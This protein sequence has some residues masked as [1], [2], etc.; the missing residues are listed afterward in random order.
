MSADRASSPWRFREGFEYPFSSLDPMSAHVDPPAVAVYET[1]LVKRPDSGADPLLAQHFDVADD[2]VTW[3]MQLRPDLRFHSGA[4]CDAAAVVEALDVLRW[5]GGDDRQ[6]WY[7]DAVDTVRVTG[8]DTIEFT[9]V[10]PSA[11]FHSLLWGTHTAIHNEA[12]RR[13]TGDAFGT[14]VADGT[15]PYRLTSWSPERIEARRWDDYRRSGSTFLTPQR[16]QTPDVIEWVSVPDAAERLAM[17]EDGELDCIHLPPVSE[18][19]RLVEDPG[20]ASY[21]HPQASSMYLTLDWKQSG[22]D[23][24]RVRQAVSAAID[25]AELVTEVFA[26][27]A[28]AAAGPLPPGHR[29]CDPVNGVDYRHDPRRAAE[30]LDA[31]GWK[32]GPDGVRVRDGVPLAVRCVIQD[33][34]TFRHVARLVAGQLAEIGVRLDVDPRRGFAA[35]YEA[36]ADAPPAVISKWLWPD[37]VDALIGFTSTS[38]APF[39][40]WSNASSAGLDAAFRDWI[41]GESD[42]QLH[43]AAAAAQRAFGEDLPYVP[44]L[45]PDDVWVWRDHDIGFQPAA[46]TLYPSYHPLSRGPL[47]AE[48]RRP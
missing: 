42:E 35:F 46:A 34:P 9:L 24:L 40:N 31:A 39:P 28:T 41:R 27:H 23:D 33:D 8:A 2:G 3:R 17:F 45:T 32:M 14:E 11:R 15:G 30:L 18:M 16:S 13:S 22:F 20:I 21:H 5:Q 25:R 29:Y 44:L 36:C 47:L 37:P 48:D 4:P 10:H 43:A 12:L 6:L 1:L 19:T 38:T 26:G 7:W